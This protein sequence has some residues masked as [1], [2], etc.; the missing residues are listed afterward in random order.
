[1]PQR[2]SATAVED[3]GIRAVFQEAFGSEEI[4]SER[5]A[6]AIVDY[7]RT[8]MSGNS[9][10]D[11]WRYDRD[12]KAVSDQV[13]QGHELFFG[14]AKCRQCHA[15]NNFTDSKFHNLGI[16]WDPEAKQFSDEGRF[17]VDEE[18]GRPRR[19]QDADAARRDEAPPYHARRVRELVA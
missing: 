13:K 12:E 7:E 1:M 17:V 3:P 5:I 14:K 8:R 18:R 2:C 4:T 16:G 19:V 11:R 6:K 10:W 9:A 15:G